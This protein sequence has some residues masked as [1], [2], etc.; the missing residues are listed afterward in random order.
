M[1]TSPVEFKLM[2]LMGDALEETGALTSQGP[3]LVAVSGGQDS[4]VLLH[5]LH[6]LEVPIM[7]AHFDHGTRAGESALD[8]QLVEDFCRKEAIL[9]CIARKSLENDARRT[10]ENFEALARRKR[11]AYLT[12]TARR[13]GCEVIVTGHHLDDQVETILLGSLGLTSGFGSSGMEPASRK[14]GFLLVRPMLHIRKEEIDAYARSAGVPWREDS[15]NPDQR[16]MRNR[17]RNTLLPVIDS[18]GDHCKTQL[19]ERAALQ[20]E[21]QHYLD[22]EGGRILKQCGR[23][24]RERGI[25]LYIDHEKLCSHPPLLVRHALRILAR[26]LKVVFDRS[27]INRIHHLLMESKPGKEYDLVDSLIL[28]KRGKE[29]M[30]FRDIQ[31]WEDDWPLVPTPGEMIHSHFSIE[32]S[33]PGSLD[34]ALQIEQDALRSVFY[35]SNP[36]IEYP[37]SL[38]LW[39]SVARMIPFGSSKEK[40]INK[41]LAE[42][43]IPPT[44]RRLECI[45]VDDSGQKLLLTSGHRG[46]VAKLTEH[47]TSSILQIKITPLDSSDPDIVAYFDSSD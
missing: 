14:D 28:Y 11:Y 22:E 30:I 8:A 43:A 46:N 41:L 19:A 13:E 18:L 12:D 3:L 31:D 1:S 15:S 35:F 4:M 33:H 9:F 2:Q 29:C 16:Y 44:L 42:R 6:R 32:T 24:G 26:I 37:L 7:A 17:V 36:E 38:R 45:I 21:M 25:L 34:V 39:D 10:G 20:R 40:S 5:V 47:N 23:A 27:D